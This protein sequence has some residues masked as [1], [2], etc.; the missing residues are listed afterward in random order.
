[1][2]QLTVSV[3]KQDHIWGSAKAPVTLLE[4]GD[5]ECPY[6]GAAYYV[7]KRIQEELEKDRMR[8]AFRNFPLAQSHP[9]ALR[10]AIAAEAAG[11]QKKFWKMHDE[12]FEN[13]NALETEDFKK[14]AKKLDLNMTKFLKDSSDEKIQ[15]RIQQ[16][17]MGGVRSGVSGTP[18]FYIN[19]VRYDGLGEYKDL[20]FA[21]EAE[22]SK[23]LGRN[24]L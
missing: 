18:T 24:Y 2:I 19:G 23:M 8:F 20:M 13:Q 16:D 10:A 6:C 17:L 7:I 12:L 9:N 4:Y 1:M 15:Q 3:G 5:Y 14:Y 21:L 22:Y 11:L